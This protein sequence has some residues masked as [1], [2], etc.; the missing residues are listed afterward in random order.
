MQV[1]DGEGK[2]Q[3]RTAR[4]LRVDRRGCDSGFVTLNPGQPQDRTST[5]RGKCGCSGGDGEAQQQRL[6]RSQDTTHRH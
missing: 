5:R 6:K 1:Q 2:R 3:Q 4:G